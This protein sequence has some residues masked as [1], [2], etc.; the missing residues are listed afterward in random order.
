[1]HRH[2]LR[3]ELQGDHFSPRLAEAKTGLTLVRKNEPG[4]I[5]TLGR[6]KGKPRPYG[7]ASLEAPDDWTW[8][9][10]WD[11]LLMTLSTHIETLRQCGADDLVLDLG[12][13]YDGQCNLEF[14][15]LRLGQVAALGIPFAI[16]CY[17]IGKGEEWESV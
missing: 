9:H 10:K 8:D 4:D 2:I 5:G 17:E 14:S 3:C 6:H 13:F 15:P 16:S 11:W 12:Y 7:A 1:M